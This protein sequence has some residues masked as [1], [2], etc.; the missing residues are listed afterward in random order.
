M[1]MLIFNTKIII[2]YALYL[3]LELNIF[4]FINTIRDFI[5]LIQSVRMLT[6][7]RIQGC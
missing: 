1:Q 3:F 2:H 4:N 7:L 5:Q 6:D